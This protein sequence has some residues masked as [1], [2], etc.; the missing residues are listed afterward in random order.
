[1][2]EVRP[3]VCPNRWDEEELMVEP[4]VAE[5]VEPMVAEAVEPL[6]A[7]PAAGMVD[8]ISPS[9]GLSFENFKVD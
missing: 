7:L 2:V 9:K 4:M 5:A 3:P 6:V 1:M 8:A